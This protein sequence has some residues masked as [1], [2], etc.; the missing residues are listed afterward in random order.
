ML[1]SYNYPMDFPPCAKLSCLLPDDISTGYNA[2]T[3]VSILYVYKYYIY[4]LLSCM[5]VG[6]L[7]GVGTLT[8]YCNCQTPE[9]WCLACA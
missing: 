3:V 9:L 7:T 8:Q 6:V 4:T 2:A 1:S 5:Y